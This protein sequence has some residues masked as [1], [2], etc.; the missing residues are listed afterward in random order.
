MTLTVMK[1]FYDK[2]E[3][4]KSILLKEEPTQ[5][6][7]STTIKASEKVIADMEAANEGVGN[8]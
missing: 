4:R 5:Q 7:T 2:E 8:H 6:S 3:R 1:Y